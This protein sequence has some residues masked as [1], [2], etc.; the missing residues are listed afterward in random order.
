VSKADLAKKPAEVAAMFDDVA[1][2]YDLTNTLLSFGQ[3]R[4]W[5]KIVRDAVFPEAG[6]TNNQTPGSEA[7][8]KL[9]NQFWNARQISCLHKSL[10]KKHRKD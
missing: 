10:D 4:R 8:F 1:P 6:Q 5:R 3:D 9:F 2:T 7:N